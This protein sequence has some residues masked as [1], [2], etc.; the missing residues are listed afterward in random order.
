MGLIDS[1]HNLDM[2]MAYDADLMVGV[3][4]I[5]YKPMTGA[6]RSISA[7]VFRDG[8]V[9]TEG[10]MTTA[11]MTIRC[12]NDSTYGIATSEINVSGDKVS[13][14]YRKGGTARDYPIAELTMS[15]EQEIEFRVQGRS[16]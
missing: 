15:D 11:Q 13:V 5:T 9:T 4:T 10:G 2:Q 12:R 1:A 3:E 6:T 14:A 7:Q 8:I 16:D